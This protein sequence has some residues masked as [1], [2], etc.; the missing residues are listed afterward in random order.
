MPL[1]DNVVKFVSDFIVL[2]ALHSIPFALPIGFAELLNK[3]LVLLEVVYTGLMEE[4]LNI[5]DKVKCSF[6]LLWNPC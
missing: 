3:H 6:R 4:E 1:L 2:R 5:F